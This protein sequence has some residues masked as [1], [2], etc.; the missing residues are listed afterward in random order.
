MTNVLMPVG[1]IDESNDTGA[2]FTFARLQD[3]ETIIPGTPVMVRNYHHDTDSHARIRGT[4]T[5]VTGHTASF[6][7]LETMIDPNWP[8]RLDPIG[9]GNPV[10]AG[11]PDSFD[12]VF[13]RERMA[14]PE[15]LEMLNEFARQHEELA[16]IKPAGAVYT[17]DQ[18]PEENGDYDPENP[19]NQNCPD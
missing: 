6:I 1:I 12:P 4:I 3:R 18:P 13:N 9:A 19:A 10:Y 15:E 5:E 14:S 11:Q 17:P 16:G 7:T 2:I 8:D